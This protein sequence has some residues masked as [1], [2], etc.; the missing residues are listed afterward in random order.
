MVA[1]I[2]AIALIGSD[3]LASPALFDQAD[4][5]ACVVGLALL[6]WTGEIAAV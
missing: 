5:R 4:E 1:F 6:T 3:L 2:H